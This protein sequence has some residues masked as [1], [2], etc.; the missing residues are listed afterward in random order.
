V[1]VTVSGDGDFNMLVESTDI[2]VTAGVDA[3]ELSFTGGGDN[4]I[5][6]R[7]DNQFV[8]DD[9]AGL[10]IDST[11]GTAKRV[12]LLVEDSSFTNTSA[13][14]QAGS[15]EMNGNILFNATIQG[16]TFDDSTS[17][18]GDF[19]MFAEGAQSRIRLNLGGDDPDDFNTAAGTGDFVIEEDVGAD[20]DVF[21][22]DDT[23]AGLRNN[24]TVVPLPNAA[25]FDDSP[26]APPLPVVP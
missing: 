15:F 25:A 19:F 20:F 6:F 2:N 8:A 11:G 16:N 12:D 4:D 26:V 13:V 14:E 9:G 22:R 23:F 1:D 24:G 21:E 7:N 10:N 17:G 3:F 5:T 18:G